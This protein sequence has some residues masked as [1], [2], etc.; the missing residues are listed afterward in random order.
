MDWMD[1]KGSHFHCMEKILDDRF[2]GIR[3]HN[4]DNNRTGW[5]LTCGRKDDG[6]HE[7]RYFG[8][9][10]REWNCLMEIVRMK[11]SDVGFTS[12]AS[13]NRSASWSV[14]VPNHSAVDRF[15]SY[16]TVQTFQRERDNTYVK[17][18]LSIVEDKEKR[19]YASLS[20][21]RSSQDELSHVYF[22]SLFLRLANGTNMEEK[23][24]MRTS[25]LEI[26][27]ETSRFVLLLA[28]SFFFSMFRCIRKKE[29]EKEDSVP[30]K[31]DVRFR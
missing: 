6:C 26:R 9:C 13:T 7:K 21:T 18:V 31:V 14:V 12:H 27:K 17:F 15:Y 8:G 2:H 5:I 3:D 20:R 25:H 30:T 1:T 4:V 29:S 10:L 16:E 11:V 23:L 22:R 24:V 19:S 28:F